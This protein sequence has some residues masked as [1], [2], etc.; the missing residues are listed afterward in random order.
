MF[1]PPKAPLTTHPFRS[2]VVKREAPD[3]EGLYAI[4]YRVSGACVYIGK[5]EEQTIKQRLNNHLTN[6]GERLEQWIKHFGEGLEFCVYPIDPKRGKGGIIDRMETI[7]I[8]M[9]LPD[10]NKNKKPR[11]Y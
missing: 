3:Q 8:N 6:P 5:A 4:V 11:G 10:V 9:W 7:M 2:G 1:T